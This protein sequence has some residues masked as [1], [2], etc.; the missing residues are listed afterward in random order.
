[1][2]PR[3]EARQYLMDIVL[4]PYLARL[5]A[6][7]QRAA[8]PRLDGSLAI[9]RNSLQRFGDS[10]GVSAGSSDKFGRLGEGISRG[11]AG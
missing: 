6:L 9:S 8:Y 3:N 11:R 1:M 10:G 7:P 2:R 5:S 4:P